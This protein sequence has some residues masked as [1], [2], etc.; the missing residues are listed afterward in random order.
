MPLVSRFQHVTAAIEQAQG[1]EKAASAAWQA[2]VADQPKGTVGSSPNTG[3]MPFNL[4]DFG[5]L[6]FESLALIPGDGRFLDVGAGPGSKMLIARDVYGLDVAGFD[7]LDFIAAIGRDAGLPVQTADADDWTGYEKFDCVWV[8]RPV[9][10]RKIEQFLEARIW[11]EMAD[12]AVAMVANT[13]TRPPQDWIIVSDQWDDLRRG[14]WVKPY[15]VPDLAAATARAEQEMYAHGFS[16]EA[17]HAP[18]GRSVLIPG[19]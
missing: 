12:G 6:L 1:L 8:N 7:V 3:W 13:E 4:F 5:S 9:R 10:D 19:T 18:P 2:W 16:G 15:L 17:L 14:A 11:Q